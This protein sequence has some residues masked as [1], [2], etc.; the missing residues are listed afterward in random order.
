MKSILTL[1]LFLLLPTPL[2]AQESLWK[3]YRDAGT[4]AYQRNEFGEAERR[5]ILARIEA[6]G[7]GQNDPRLGLTY[8]DLALVYLG[9]ND[10]PQAKASSEKALEV[11]KMTKWIESGRTLSSQS[12]NSLVRVASTFLNKQEYDEIERLLNEALRIQLT[13]LKEY[14]SAIATTLYYLSITNFL[15]SRKTSDLPSSER[16][17][18]EA[19]NHVSEV[20]GIYEKTGDFVDHKFFLQV[21]GGF[22]IID[23]PKAESFLKRALTFREQN[24]EPEYMELDL[25]ESLSNLYDNQARFQES[26]GV[27]RRRLEITERAFGK[28]DVH[29]GAVLDELGLVLMNQEK[30]AQ[31]EPFLKRA[32]DVREAQHLETGGLAESLNTLAKNYYYQGSYSEAEPRFVRAIAMTR[33]LDEKSRQNLGRYN[34]NYALVLYALGRD[35]DADSLFLDYTKTANER[36]TVLALYEKAE[37][38]RVLKKYDRSEPLYADVLNRMGKAQVDPYTHAKALERFSDLLRQT[39]R[40]SE[41]IQREREAQKIRTDAARNN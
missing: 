2:T 30:Y 28:D 21:L 33:K 20:L 11:W 8:C 4:L 36:T 1:F 23:A 39:N 25:L 16:K 13:V 18:K 6:E 37:L 32:V 41:A 12:A 40:V 5:F 29:L 27:S 22:A 38:Y 17:L 34:K 31:A 10:V 26:E 24:D 35:G 3:A 15:Q 14:D 19:R 9:K 7:F